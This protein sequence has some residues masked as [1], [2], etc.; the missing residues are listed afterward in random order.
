MIL[1]M[2]EGRIKGENSQVFLRFLN[3]FRAYRSFRLRSLLLRYRSEP[4]AEL[5][6]SLSK[7]LVDLGD[8]QSAVKYLKDA[9]QRFSDSEEIRTVLSQ[10]TALVVRK[11][12]TTLERDYR[13]APR[14]RD[15][16][17]LI[18]LYRCLQNFTQ[19]EKLAEGASAS[20]QDSWMVQ[21]AV[22]KA[23][24]HRFLKE[25]DKEDAARS[26][27]ALRRARAMKP[28]STQV[29]HYL[30]ALLLAVGPQAEAEEVLSEL[31][32]LLPGDERVKRMRGFL[33]TRAAG[34]RKPTAAVAEREE[35]LAPLERTPA[36]QVDALLEELR[37]SPEIFGAFV[38]SP[39][40]TLLSHH[41]TDHEQFSLE[42]HESA[43]AGLAR[44]FR[45]AAERLGIGSL[46]SCVV[47]GA[48]PW[49]FYL[50]ESGGS[51][52]AVFADRTFAP[53]RFES[54]AGRHSLE[55]IQP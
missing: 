47:E 5:A 29:L 10:L 14:S 55:P 32:L 43:I 21:L 12:I 45:G 9:R 42:G 35:V 28:T 54:L 11:E 31:S 3:P 23:F 26:A 37:Q 16:A 17:R 7:V 52:L 49:W 2:R 46:D 38:F 6:L 36:E 50:L 40:G 24:F 15:L 44:S 30:A 34:G 39:S 22:G 20:L 33:E 25:R 8:P 1:S 53:D 4:S 51:E 18:E 48:G 13:K 27:E 19:C 41:W